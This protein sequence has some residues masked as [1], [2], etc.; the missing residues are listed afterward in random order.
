MFGGMWRDGRR[1]ATLRSDV[2]REVA[3]LAIARRPR[4]LRVVR[5]RPPVYLRSD[6]IF[7]VTAGGSVGHIAGVLNNLERTFSAPVFCTTADI[8]T[9]STTL[10]SHRIRPLGLPWDVP[11]LP[12]L[13]FNS[14]FADG[15]RRALNGRRPGFFYHRYSLNDY[16]SIVLAREYDVPLVLEYNG[17]EVWAHR[18]WGTP[19]RHEALASRIERLNL[20]AADLIVVVSDRLREQL[21]ADGIEPE[22]ILVNPNG[23]D[24]DVYRP[25]VDG[26]EIRKRFDLGDRLVVGFIGT[27]GRWHGTAVLAEA[28]A[29]AVQLRPEYRDR[30]RLLMIGDGLMLAPTRQVLRDAG[31]E[32]HAVFTG[33]VP[34]EQGPRYLAACDVLVSPTVPNA[35]GSPFFGSPTKLFEYMAM[36]KAVVA[37][38]LDQL[39]QVLRHDETALLTKPG[40]VDSLCRAL[41]ALFD[42]E[43]LRDRLGQAARA[44]AVANHSW[45]SHTARIVAELQSGEDL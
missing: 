37:S 2:E 33:M 45:K 16:S 28:F 35:D 43:R 26:A 21:V 39:G 36:G 1:A 5:G 3:R 44:A 12:P 40:D 14:V 20:E 19:V 6:L 7:G 25:Y 17:S 8:P 29:K 11:E 32:S 23:V 22:K 10:E 18:N 4:R 42:D 9:V 15:V 34:Q 38:D 41:L 24:T 30:V 31:L 27:F 13:A